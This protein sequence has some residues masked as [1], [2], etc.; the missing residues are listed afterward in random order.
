VV[1]ELLATFGVAPLKSVAAFY[2]SGVLCFQ[3]GSV[4]L[5]TM[6]ADRSIQALDDW[7]YWVVQGYYF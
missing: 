5:A 3:F 2:E 7:H 1:A 6:D 4:Q